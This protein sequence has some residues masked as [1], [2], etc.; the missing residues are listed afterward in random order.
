[1]VGVFQ[2]AD[3]PRVDLGGGDD[4]VTPTLLP[5]LGKEMVGN[6]AHQLGPGLD[7]ARLGFFGLAVPFQKAGTALFER[8]RNLGWLEPTEIGR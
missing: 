8:M 7:G 6:P 3:G 5:G 4:G 2:R 1:V